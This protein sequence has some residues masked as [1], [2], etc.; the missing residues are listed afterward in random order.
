VP[1]KSVRSVMVSRLRHCD[2]H[3][4]WTVWIHAQGRTGAE[5][6]H[7][8][9]SIEPLIGV[10]TARLWRPAPAVPQCVSWSM[11]AKLGSS[12]FLEVRSSKSAAHVFFPTILAETGSRTRLSEDA[13]AG[14]RE[15]ADTTG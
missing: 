3:F 5:V 7:A 9:T 14:R 12:P 4:R 2:G 11:G 1:R 6:E 8:G 13:R 15:L 10:Y